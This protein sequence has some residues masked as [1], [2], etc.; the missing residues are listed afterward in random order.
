MV[1]YKEEGG[2]KWRVKYLGLY[3]Y[4]SI[5]IYTIGKGLGKK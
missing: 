2:R 4:I 3:I 1:M 5:Y